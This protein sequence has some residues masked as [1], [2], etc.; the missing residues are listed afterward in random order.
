MFKTYAQAGLTQLSDKEVAISGLLQR[1]QRVLRSKHV[2]GIFRCFLSKLLLWRVSD[3]TK[4]RAAC[5]GD[6]E[7]GLPSWSWMSHDH[8]EFFPKEDIHVPANANEFGSNGQLHVQ[9]F[10]LHDWVTEQEQ[11]ERHVILRDDAQEIG[12]F[13][14]DM[15]TKPQSDHCV[16]VGKSEENTW[17]VVLVTE[18]GEKRYKRF[19][20]GRIEPQYIS[21]TASDGVLV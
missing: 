11:G 3:T 10:R 14:F 21:E 6:T 7:H 15:Q 17:F 19:G 13:W 9:I 4:N 8:I 2:H 5:S 12:E 16:V 20:I 1:I 18:I